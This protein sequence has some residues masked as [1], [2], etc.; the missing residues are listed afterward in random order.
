MTSRL[1]R[2]LSRL[3]SLLVMSLCLWSGTA[4]ATASSCN[5]LGDGTACATAC[6][7]EG[8]CKSNACIATKL[9]P[10]GSS[11]ISENRC[12]MNDVCMNGACTNGTP[13]MC[14]SNGCH[15]GVCQPQFGCLFLNTCKP[16]MSVIV[17]MSHVDLASVDDLG[18][19]TDLARAV[20]MSVTHEDLG[21]YFD[22]AGTDLAPPVGD[23]CYQPPG[24]EFELCGGADGPFVRPIDGGVVDASVR[25]A[26]APDAAADASVQLDGGERGHL[27]GSRPGDCSIAPGERPDGTPGPRGT[28]ALLAMLA[29][30]VVA[31]RRRA[32]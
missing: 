11:C 26:G 4:H 32:A 16:D 14:P 8:T 24:A 2:L 17:D 29:L 25:D 1:A 31:L 23:M 27:R 3:A 10:D 21:F 19:S 18:P 12:T 7:L 22:L 20:D 6:I 28:L 15:I 9:Q 5:G 30:L 13:I